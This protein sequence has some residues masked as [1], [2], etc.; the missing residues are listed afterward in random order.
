MIQL[1]HI[2]LSR[3]YR[4]G[5]RQTELLIKELTRYSIDQ[6]LVARKNEMLASRVR[7][8]GIRVIETHG[9]HTNPSLLLASK[10]ADIIH[11][12]E[13]RSPYGAYLSKVF[14][15]KR[16]LIT[17]RVDNLIKSNFLSH[18]VYRNADYVVC[19]AKKV[20]DVVNKFDHLIRTEVI[21][22]CCSDLSIDTNNVKK[23]KLD[24]KGKFIVG[25]VGALDNSQKKQE[26][27]INV[28]KSL[29]DKYPEIHFFLVGGGHDSSYFKELAK[30]C[31]NIT[32]T[33]FVENVGDYLALFDIFILPSF[34]EGIGSILIDAM[35]KKLP[36][37]ASD[38]GGVSEIVKDKINGYLIKHGD[39]DNLKEKILFLKDNPL[40]RDSMS[41][42]GKKIASPL[43]SRNM[44]LKYINIYRKMV[45]N[46]KLYL[47]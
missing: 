43:T 26:D 38:V 40:I 28:A 31:N 33:G 2:N 6:T 10:K 23:I 47:I 7:N 4:G 35:Q 15:N 17:R 27:I 24:Y 25:H 20:S 5:E 3:G 37:I 19:V 11:C 22:S 18:R 16:Y 29:K 30:G 21:H 32:F 46:G 42:E 13:G 1:T 14:F 8:L 44:C 45:K 41:K 34:R 36:I 9:L 39:K 12:H